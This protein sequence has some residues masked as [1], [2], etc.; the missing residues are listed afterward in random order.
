M[1]KA[2]FPYKKLV[3]ILLSGTLLTLSPPGYTNTVELHKTA[4]EKLVTVYLLIDTPE[5]LL[6]YTHDLGKIAKPNF[7]RVIFSFVRPT[8]EYQSGNLANSG[9]LGYFNVGD[10]KGVQAFNQLKDAI[11]LSKQKNI[12]TFLSVGGW[13][14]SCN[15]SVYG[16]LCGPAPHEGD[17]YDFFPDPTDPTQ[18]SMAEK[19]YANLVKL[20]NDLEVDGI[21]FDYEE[22]W[23]ADQYAVSWQPGALGEWATSIAKNIQA[24]G[25][26]SYANLMKFGTDSSAGAGA[27]VMPKTISKVNTILHAIIDN[28]ASKKLLFATAAP[29][30]GARP[31]TG[32][33]YGD[34]APNIYEKGG[35][36]WKGNLKGL[37]YHLN[38]SDPALVARF[39]SLGLMTYDLCGDNPT[40]CAPYGG[41]PL[42]L[43]GQVKAYMQDYS[44]WLK[45]SNVSEAKLSIDTI[46]K[47]T[48]LPA[49]YHVKS[50]IQFGFEVNRPAYPKNPE[51]ML[52]LTNKLVDTITSEQ[53]NSDGVI[54][55]EMYSR[56]NTDVP[57][58]TTVQYT[59]KQ[60]CKAFLGNDDRYDCEA[61]FPGRI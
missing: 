7:N 50:K 53:K 52:Q 1:P 10:G 56:Q 55:W 48:F 31:I 18:K 12:Q 19:S 22:F 26:P 6:K 24:A 40:I 4:T 61:D 57:D 29:P 25:G 33:V 30:V 49:K 5:R 44:N 8:M 27:A 43:P 36:W 15:Y 23:H 21:D 54:I 28:P 46:G 35:L 42:D 16:A 3:A 11:K 47:V 38:E 45:S 41:G 51:G 20:A 59:I 37:W 32:F 17:N 14:Y 58:A 39:D 9:I 2:I 34:T 60:S 13:N